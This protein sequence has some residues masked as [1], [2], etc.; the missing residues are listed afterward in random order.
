MIFGKIIN[1][2]FPDKIYRLAGLALFHIH[3]NMEIDPDEI[4]CR[5]LK[6]HPRRMELVIILSD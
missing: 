1:K 2:S 6:L 4:I 3:Y 5:F